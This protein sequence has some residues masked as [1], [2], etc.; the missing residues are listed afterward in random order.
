MAYI[1]TSHLVLMKYHQE[2][3][4]IVP[5]RLAQYF[6]LYSP[7]LCCLEYC[8]MIGFL[9]ILHL[10]SKK[11]IKETHQI[12]V[13]ISLTAICCKIMEHIIYH[14]IMEHLK[15]YNILC[16]YHGVWVQTGP[17]FRNTTNYSCRGHTICNGSSPTG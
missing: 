1:L 7:S 11:E 13:P 12:I 3:L 15:N 10:F 16:N 8:L 9:Q 6:K 14:S 5:L 17:L 2:F 4:N